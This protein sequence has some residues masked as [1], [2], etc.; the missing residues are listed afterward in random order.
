[1]RKSENG[2][3]AN[4]EEGREEAGR[5]DSMDWPTTRPVAATA[6]A[7]PVPT[8]YIPRKAVV[9]CILASTT[10][11]AGANEIAPDPQ[12]S[13]EPKLLSSCQNLSFDTSKL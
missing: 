5:F 6:T 11:R 7:V 10:W 8:S 12:S 4:G 1:M 13:C 2:S 9:S 3:L